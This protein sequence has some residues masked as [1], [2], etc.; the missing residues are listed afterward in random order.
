MSAYTQ[1]LH[2]AEASDF[3]I[4]FLLIRNRVL[5]NAKSEWKCYYCDTEMHTRRHPE[6]IKNPKRFTIDH[7]IPT[8]RGGPDTIFNRVGACC[9]CNNLKGWMTEAEFVEWTC[10]TFRKQAA[11]EPRNVFMRRLGVQGRR[12]HPLPHHSGIMEEGVYL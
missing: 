4:T 8:S 7:L 1:D 2:V 12:L 3:Y 11:K 6:P 9:A 10:G 5:A